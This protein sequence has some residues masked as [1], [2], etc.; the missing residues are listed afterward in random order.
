[1]IPSEDLKKFIAEIGYRTLSEIQAK[2]A[3]ADPEVL[4]MSITYLI[5]QN[6]IRRIKFQKVSKTENEELFYIPY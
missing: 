4:L 1:M 2:F 3:E 6:Q 5:T